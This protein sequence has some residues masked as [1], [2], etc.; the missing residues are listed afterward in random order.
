MG[1]ATLLNKV[2]IIWIEILHHLNIHQ[3][4]CYRSAFLKV[5]TLVVF[6]VSLFIIGFATLFKYLHYLQTNMLIVEVDLRQ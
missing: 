4:I 5:L 6:S 1:F 2:H 3:V